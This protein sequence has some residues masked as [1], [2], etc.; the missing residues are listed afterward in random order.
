MSGFF[1]AADDEPR[2]PHQLIAEYFNGAGLGRHADLLASLV[3][4]GANT[5]NEE[6]QNLQVPSSEW[7]ARALRPRGETDW[8][9]KG[10]I[11]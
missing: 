4:L 11:S 8:I 9:R 10:R 2:S 1:D 6:R 7:V 5:K 3:E